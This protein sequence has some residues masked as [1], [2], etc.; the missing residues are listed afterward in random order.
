MAPH[1]IR[2][3]RRQE[4]LSGHGHCLPLTLS[5]VVVENEANEGG[6]ML[7]LVLGGAAFGKS[8]A[9]FTMQWLRVV[10]PDFFG[11]LRRG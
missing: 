4:R 10:V 8:R 1:N 2:Q 7:H 5:W 3:A 11:L 9:V 6:T